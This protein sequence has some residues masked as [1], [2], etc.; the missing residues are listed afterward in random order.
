[1]DTPAPPRYTDQALAALRELAQE[2]PLRLRSSGECM[3]PA[4]PGNARLEVA[5]RSRYWPGDVVVFGAA[6][7]RLLVHRVAGWRRRGGS[8]EYITRA[9]RA[10]LHDAPVVD[11]RVVGRV[12]GGE[13]AG[14]TARVSFA[15]RAG[16]AAWL[17]GYALRRLAGRP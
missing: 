14:R 1:M 16:A 8:L 5:A 10:R 2:G 17:A 6:D 12:V 15:E 13:D 9:D 3:V 7:G 11:S 4:L